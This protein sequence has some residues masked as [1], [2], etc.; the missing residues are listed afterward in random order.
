[1]PKTQKKWYKRKA[2]IIALITV[3]IPA[4]ASIMVQLISSSSGSQQP[5]SQAVIST[6][7]SL[8][9]NFTKAFNEIVNGRGSRGVY[10]LG[11]VY[12]SAAANVP[13]QQEIISILVLYVSA[14]APPMPSAQSS[15]HYCL[16]PPQNYPAD[17]NDALKVIGNR[18]PYL[19]SQRI[20]LSHINLAY[21][22]LDDFN[23]Q[24]RKLRQRPAVQDNLLQFQF[25]GCLFRWCRSA[26]HQNHGRQGFDGRSVALK[27]IRC[28]RLSSQRLSR[29]TS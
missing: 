7:F 29:P 3:G 15:S 14:N 10:D 28:T 18:N 20:N 24:E 11:M 5:P 9:A 13:L 2:V 17:L 23:L 25:S 4:I 6:R 8:Q 22:T 19:I 27:H 21:A 12:Y 1:V 16:A 26:I